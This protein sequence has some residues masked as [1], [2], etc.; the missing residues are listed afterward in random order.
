MKRASGFTVIEVLVVLSFL[1]VGAVLF[2]TQ[3]AQIEAASRDTQR[4]TAINAMYY[5]LEEV[6]YEKNGYYPQS[7]DSK[8][9]RSVDPELFYDPAGRGVSDSE[10][11]YHY[12][13]RGCSLDGKC[14]SYVL[15]SKMER[16]SSFEK[17]SRRS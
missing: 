10:S 14:T 7:I 6:F 4:K 17:T 15:H 13:S 5:S 12:D 16:E 8:T 1:L 9:L 11:D 2:I 3:S